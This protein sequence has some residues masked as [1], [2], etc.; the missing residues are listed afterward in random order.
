M[1]LKKAILF[2]DGS[3]FYHALKQNR[4]FD[5]F[6]YQSFVE[7]LSKEFEIVR[8]YYYDAIKNAGLEP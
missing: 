4:F 1:A 2:I 6:S 8:V 5:Q 7:E 3:N